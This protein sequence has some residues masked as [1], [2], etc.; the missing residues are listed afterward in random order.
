MRVAETLDWKGLTSFEVTI[1]QQLFDSSCSSSRTL[2]LSSNDM[3]SNAVPTQ[4]MTNPVIPPSPHPILCTIFLSYFTTSK[5]SFFT[6]GPNELLHPQQ[7]LNRPSQ[8]MTGCRPYGHRLYLV[9]YRLLQIVSTCF[10][11]HSISQIT[12]LQIC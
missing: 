7:D 10:P 11:H 9:L 6:D 12:V 2:Y 4:G 8:H 3:F 1:T 5:N